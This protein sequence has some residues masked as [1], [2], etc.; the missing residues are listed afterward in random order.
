MTLFPKKTTPR[1]SATA[2]RTLEAAVARRA[3]RSPMIEEDEEPTT[4][5]KTALVVVLLLHVVAGGG[6]LMFD[7]IKTHR[8]SSGAATAA[9]AKT[10]FQPA[11]APAAV[12]P[13]PLAAPVVS[14]SSVA[15]VEVAKKPVAAPVASAAPA[16]HA[17]PVAEVK[18]TATS[19]TVAKG[20]TALSIAKKLHVSYDEL[21]KLNKIADP[22]KLR[23]GQK[24]HLPA[25]TRSTAN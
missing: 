16:T 19:Y 11:A 25:K 10:A 1:S 14:T 24:L 6:I 17:A 23:I 8:L 15:P 12:R 9:P 2:R 3:S 7:R 4:S 13:K 22:K 20:D 21:L 18:H 5:F